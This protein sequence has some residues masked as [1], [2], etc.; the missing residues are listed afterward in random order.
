M[1]TPSDIIRA[2]IA[3]SREL[4]NAATPAPWINADASVLSEHLGGYYI[5]QYDGQKT[6]HAKDWENAEF[7]SFARTALPLRDDAL[8]IAERGLK[9]I[10]R[11]DQTEL[12]EAIASGDSARIIEVVTGMLNRGRDRAEKT[13]A[14][15]AAKLEEKP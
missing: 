13:L 3:R 1:S 6:T 14:A 8:E 9:Q 2:A 5:A 10:S 11:P 15:I 7:S 4:S 12:R